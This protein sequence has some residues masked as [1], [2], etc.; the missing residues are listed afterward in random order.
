MLKYRF[1]VGDAL[2]RTGVNMYTAKKT[3]II[4]Q[5]TLRKVKNNDTSI[6]LDSLNK[7]CAILDMQPKDIIMYVEDETEKKN[8]SEKLRKNA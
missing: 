6:S 4:S 7:I 1:D 2:E 5:N 3:K 8:I